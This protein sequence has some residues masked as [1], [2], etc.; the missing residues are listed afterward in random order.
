MGAD[1]LLAALQHT[2]DGTGGHAGAHQLQHLLF[3]AAQG[4]NTALSA[5]P[6][7]A[8]VQGDPGLLAEALQRQLQFCA[9]DGIIIAPINAKQRRMLVLVVS[10]AV[11]EDQHGHLPMARR[12][13]RALVAAG[14]A[15]AVFQRAE[16]DFYRLH[17]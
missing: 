14:T 15:A 7:A 17:I 10:I 6:D 5:F 4:G 2:G 8:G 1:G 16:D 3:A 9:N 11:V 13:I 12:L